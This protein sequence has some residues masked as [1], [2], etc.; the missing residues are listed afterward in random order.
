MR[1]G[2]K[3]ALVVVSTLLVAL[4]LP[5][6]VLAQ[7]SEPLDLEGETFV[8]RLPRRIQDV[9]GND[10]TPT[11]RFVAIE[12]MSQTA[13]LIETANLYTL[14]TYSV[15]GSQLREGT[16]SLNTTG[17]WGRASLEAGLNE[18]DVASTGTLLAYVPGGVLGTASS[19]SAGVLEDSP[20]TLDSGGWTTLNVTTAGDL[21]I[22]VA[23]NSTLVGTVSGYV[24]GGRGAQLVLAGTDRVALVTPGT[25]TV[26]GL[27]FP[28]ETYHR[29]FPPGEQFTVDGAGTFTVY[30]PDGCYGTV[31]GSGGLTVNGEEEVVLEAGNNS[32]NTAATTGT[33]HVNV[34]TNLNFLITGRVY[35]RGGNIRSIRGAMTGVWAVGEDTAALVYLRVNARAETLWE[36]M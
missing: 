21:D 34:G 10:V 25:G 3:M 1:K 24:G 30:L 2:R 7:S 12:V 9:D 22:L 16:A 8:F 31:T 32:I 19:G 36:W 15:R 11:H 17:W 18:I 33:L 13:G 28:D 27:P 29:V 20:V 35:H 26:V 6:V 5:Y 4:L 14:E 23:V